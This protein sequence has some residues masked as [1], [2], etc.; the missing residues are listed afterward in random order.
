MQKL[1]FYIITATKTHV[2][3]A[4]KPFCNSDRRCCVTR[5]ILIDPNT[6]MLYREFFNFVD[7][8]AAS[9]KAHTNFVDESVCLMVDNVR[10]ERKYLTCGPL[11]GIMFH[12]E[13]CGSCVRVYDLSSVGSSYQLHWPFV[14]NCS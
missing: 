8:C 5:E 14:L 1:L 13:L 7:P 4:L 10:N 12:G 11:D 2:N 9:R 6:Y 3:Y